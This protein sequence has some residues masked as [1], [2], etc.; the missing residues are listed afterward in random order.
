MPAETVRGLRRQSLD[1]QNRL[2]FVQDIDHVSAIQVRK[3]SGATLVSY[4]IPTMPRN[5]KDAVMPAC[6]MASL[7]MTVGQRVQ[8]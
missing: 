2:F 6:T 4:A 7:M 5:V 3:K 8:K 1:P